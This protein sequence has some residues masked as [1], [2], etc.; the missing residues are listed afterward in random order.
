MENTAAL[1]THHEDVRGSA[2]STSTATLR[3]LTRYK[4]WASEVLFEGFRDMPTLASIPEFDLIRLAL[5]HTL[6]VDLIFQAH[7]R[8]V[9]HD[10]GATRSPVLRSLEELATSIREVD[11]WYVEYV[12][13]TP[14]PALT[15]RVDIR[16]TDG[17][18]RAMSP[19]EMILHVVTHGIYHRGNV[20]VL[21]QKNGLVPHRDG[22]PE[23]LE[24]GADSR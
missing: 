10:F 9:G 16:F 20:G 22:L 8:G 4:A 18:V 6:V 1:R 2:S 11:R 24:S 15:E 23:Y 3:T 5:D 14:E 7:L 12:E 19:V 17:K 21:L 13:R